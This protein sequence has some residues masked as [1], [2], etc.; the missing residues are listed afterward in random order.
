MDRAPGAAVLFVGLTLSAWLRFDRGLF[1]MSWT[2]VLVSV[3]ATFTI[4]LLQA[5]RAPKVA[6]P[7][8][9]EE[10]SARESFTPEEEK[11]FVDALRAHHRE[12]QLEAWRDIQQRGPVA[13]I[14]PRAVFYYFWLCFF[15]LAVAP[16]AAVPAGLLPR[17]PR[18]LLVL[19]P[20]AVVAVAVAV[21]IGLR[22]W[23]RVLRS[24]N[25]AN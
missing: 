2:A 20:L 7:T 19:L 21:P 5:T 9:V 10:L 16:P 14:G 6:M 4:W 23:K 12:D 24:L 15:V 8:E 3:G 1:M 13:L 17:L 22:D 11:R 18:F 25:D